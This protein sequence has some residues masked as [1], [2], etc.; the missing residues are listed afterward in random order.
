MANG[1]TIVSVRQFD[2]QHPAEMMTWRV[3]AAGKAEREYDFS[4][5]GQ[6]ALLNI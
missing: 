1:G 2:L 3:A 4:E 6:P 5:V